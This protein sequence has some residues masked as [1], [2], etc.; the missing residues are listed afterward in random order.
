MSTETDF[1]INIWR[2]FGFRKTPSALRGLQRA[3]NFCSVG[4]QFAFKPSC[5]KCE[6][7]QLLS[8]IK[9]NLTVWDPSNYVMEYWCIYTSCV[10]TFFFFFFKCCFCGCL[11]AVTSEDKGCSEARVLATFSVIK[12]GSPRWRSP[13]C[14]KSALSDYT[15]PE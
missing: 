15:R 2:L 5:L 11:C 13:W 1:E 4:K 12:S 10:H 7:F 9:T 3:T 6:S 8:I 14:W